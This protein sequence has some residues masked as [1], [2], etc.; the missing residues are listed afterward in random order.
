MSDFREA[1]AARH[2]FATTAGHDHMAWA[3]RI[4]YRV[5]RGCT[6]LTPI[7]VAFARQALQEKSPEA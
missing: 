6:F 2:P 3:K 7:Q 1:A 4:L 5:E